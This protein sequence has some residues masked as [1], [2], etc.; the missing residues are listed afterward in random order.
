[1]VKSEKEIKEKIEKDYKEDSL[2][3]GM[4]NGI[5]PLIVFFKEYYEKGFENTAIPLT[6]E[7]IIKEMEDYF[8]FAWKKATDERGLSASRSI[9]KYKQWLWALED[10]ELLSFVLEDDNYNPYGKPILQKIKAK[11]KFKDGEK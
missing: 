5:H 2:M 7:N 4:C 8:S 11:Y 10:F 9:W 6:K 3:I 1:M